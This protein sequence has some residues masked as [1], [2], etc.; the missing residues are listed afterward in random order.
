MRKKGNTDGGKRSTPRRRF[1]LG[2][3]IG[4]LVTLIVGVVA[5]VWW[6]A[7][8]ILAARSRAGGAAKS[9]AQQ[10]PHSGVIGEPVAPGTR[11]PG[12]VNV[13]L[14]VVDTQRADYLTPYG[15]TLPTTPFLAEMAAQGITFTKVFST[16]SW[17]PPSMYSMHTGLY[18]TEHGITS[19][20]TAGQG[21]GRR[22]RGQPVLPEEAVT[23]AEE[24][25]KHG[26]NT[27][28]INTNHHL[29]AKFG[30]A[31]GFDRFSGEQ[32]SFLPFPNLM[33]DALAGEIRGA[34]KYFLWLH[35]FDPH[36]PY[37]PFAP[38]FDQWNKS[39]YKNITDFSTEMTLKSFRKYEEIDPDDPINP[40]YMNAIY[41]MI[42]ALPSYQHA[43]TYALNYLEGSTP[44]EDFV[45]FLIAA[46]KTEIRY[47]DDAMRQAL[48]AIGID[49]QTLVVITSDHGEEFYDHKKVGHRHSLYQELIHVPLVIRLPGNSAAGTV[50]DTPVSL[51]DIMP[52]ILDVLELPIPDG[53]SG[54]SLKPLI[55]GAETTSRTL[56]CEVKNRLGESRCIVEY[57]W[58]LIYK[59]KTDTMELYNLEN[60][61]REKT[62][63]SVAESKRAK[64]MQQ[65]LSEWVD[66]TVPRWKAT[67]LKRLSK[68]ELKQLREMGYI[69]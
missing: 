46:Y 57:P 49:D 66:E 19:G 50:I 28:G 24:L 1:W 27:F 38:W 69:Q 20:A 10:M 60:D 29:A 54:V 15:E 2:L 58:K 39:A 33:V 4:V 34:S 47:T 62:N 65:R 42:K 37:R 55:E 61:P 12:T 35:Y 25:K 9:T 30:L 7:A 22:V 31:Q 64:A 14:V 48:A 52:T 16:S 53:I 67:P 21:D 11:A 17:T 41:S 26:F 13:A 44:L 40:Q 63:L 56:Y 23:L 8:P 59:Y 45:E 5:F 6:A 43:I 36:F 3:A 18:P 51:V 68:Q 32:F